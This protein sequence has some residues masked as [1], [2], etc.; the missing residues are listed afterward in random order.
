MKRG[1][2]IRAVMPKEY[3]GKPSILQPAPDTTNHPFGRYSPLRLFAIMLASIFIAEII[4]MGVVYIIP[5][6][7]YILTTLIDAGIM[8]VLIFP[9]LYRFSFHPLLQHIEKLQ[10]AEESLRLLSNV[11]EQTADTVV[12]TDCDGVIE[13]VNPAFEK[14]TGYSKEDAL[15]QT[16][17]VLKSG[18]HNEQFYRILWDTVLGGQIFHGEITNRKKNGELFHEVKTVTPLRD[19]QGAI[20]RFVATGKDIT[21]RKQAEEKLRRA[22]DDLEVRVQE[23]TE[24]LQIA[25]SE[26]EDEIKVRRRTEDALQQSEQHLKRAQE[27]AHLGSW[28]LDLVNNQLT[29]SDE[30][31]RIFGLQPQEFAATY[32]AFLE[33]VH[34]DDRAAVDEAYAGSIRDGRDIYEIE[35]R[36]VRRS[37]G[38]IRIVHE[39]CEHFRDETGRII[40]SVGM[41]HDITERK[42]AEEQLARVNQKLKEILVS[43]QDD[44][45]VLDRNWNFAYASRLFTAK[46]G[47]EP[48]DFVGENLWTLF[49]KHVGTVLEEN[50]RAA[51]EK[52]EIRRFEVGGKYTSAWYRM[53]AFPSPEGIT[54]IGTDVTERKK[55]EEALQQNEAMLRTVLDQM[56]SGVTV[57]DASTGE[58]ILANARSREI[59]GT[60]VYTADQ[61]AEYHGLHADG[62]PYQS[63]EWPLSRSIATGDRV[64][65]EEIEFLGSNGARRAISISSAP[66]R[67]SQ[68]GIVSGVAVFHDITERK[69]TE[70]RLHQL[71]R[72]LRALS[73]T[74]QVMIRATSEGQY[75]EDVCKIVVEDCG[76]S[77]VWIGY[78]QNDEVKSVLPVA[79]AGFEAGYLETL[80][81]SWADNDRGRGPTGIAIRTGKTSRCNN[82]LTD[83]QFAPW[84]EEAIKR[85]YAAS[86]VLPLLADGKAFGALNI[87]AREP[88][89][90]STDEEA[91]LTELAGDLAYGIQA[92]RL[93]EAHDRAEAQLRRARDELEIRVRERTE[94]LATANCELSEEIAERKEIERQLRIQ[95]A[96]MDSAANGIIITDPQGL[97]LWTNP[98]IKQIS[99]YETQ[100]LVGQSTHI[101]NSGVHEPDFYR[102]MWETILAGKVWH[103]ETTNR[104]KDAGLYVEEQT[105]TPV[106]NE[107]G[108]ISHFIA[109]KQDVTER[110][111][112]YSQL[113]D[114][115]RDLR[116]LTASE[117]QQRFLAEGLVES[118]VALNMS[119]ELHAVLD[120]IFEQTRRT[121]PYLIAD[122][123]LIQDGVA[124]VVQRWGGNSPELGTIPENE[125][126]RMVDFPIW[127]QILETKS[128][129]M[130]SDTSLDNRWN[131]NFDTEWIRSYIGAPLIYGE[132]V[133]GIIN[134]GSDQ[135]NA[136]HPDMVKPLAAFAAPAAVAIQ[137]ARLYQDEQQN[138]KIAE[139]LSTASLALSQTLDIEMVMETIL[140]YMQ[141]ILP[142]HVAFVILSEGD[143]R[144]RVRAVRSEGEDR[145]QYDGLKD[146]T[147]DVLS[148]PVVGP[149]FASLDSTFIPDSRQNANWSPPFELK[150]MNC[151]LGIPLA[152]IGKALGMVVI[153]NANPDSFTKYQVG[154]AEAVVKQAVVALQNAWLFEQVRSG[155]ER[156][157]QLSRHLVEVQENERKFIARELHDETS[158]SLTS[159][160]M[161]LQIIEQKAAGDTQVLEQVRNLKHLADE[162]LESLHHLAVNLRPASLDHLG[163]VE[164]LTGLIESTRQRSGLTAHFK[165]MGSIQ[166]AA[167]TEEIEASIYRIVQESLTN[168]VRHAH[169]SYAD[170]ILEWRDDGIVII[171]EDDGVGLDLQKA[172]ETGHLGLVGM[173]ERAEMLGGKLLVDS[174]PQSGTTLV[175]EIPY[176]NTNTHS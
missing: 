52:R 49:P 160:K 125:N 81:I 101:F 116:K 138:R 5:P 148:E 27:I 82:M 95:T 43:I 97:I 17:R 166:A 14:L 1:I 162:T 124:N 10:M 93:R 36:V 16:P 65:G 127:E 72:T 54:V 144:Y 145:M 105:I 119:L 90:F 103:G 38:E 66:I 48:E 50:F 165:T 69:R 106:Q 42:Q 35:H 71:N 152:S 20:R 112:I 111:L 113:E 41:V 132:Q 4:A 60:L 78:A 46:I 94:E 154:L 131:S 33:S 122:V 39:K 158:Q 167:L 37:T 117:R 86:L 56:P 98:A 85:G 126:L 130:I 139:V 110:N 80:K 87:Y 157:Q 28:E 137:N 68:G 77:M 31:F 26:L 73:N 76:H 121:I 150:A 104:R 51:M 163:L 59:M 115:N 159:L 11:I 79:S 171:V 30:V 172:R 2:K 102:Q 75:L 22:H 57:R 140:D 143:E 8:L 168:I 142:V 107:D 120:R 173:Q 108:E 19:E 6:V 55:A 9:I 176:A 134:L 24:E 149:F 53:T 135:A 62:R 34:G 133:I 84:R 136:F 147:I 169:A 25:N 21:E 23:R 156:L 74:N 64:D 70:E 114:S 67:D 47:K 146:R 161:G 13:Y 99:G 129:V 128:A 170:V 118:S 45:Y 92:I 151:W 88:G 91:L 7:P 44:F 18:V 32:E 40:R 89:A 153:A 123:V 174:T 29:W 175:V 109:I 63:E 141:F 155:R 164:A 83:P 96:A 61:F 100:E 3:P 15:G 12:V 58:I